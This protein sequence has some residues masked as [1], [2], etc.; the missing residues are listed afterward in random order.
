MTEGRVAKN[1]QVA[2]VVTPQIQPS[3]DS[4]SKKAEVGV[5]LFRHFGLDFDVDKNTMEQLKDIS[6]WAFKDVDT[7]G[8][9]LL[10]IR[11]LEVTLGVPSGNETRTDKIHRWITLQKHIEDLRNRQEAIRNVR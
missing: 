8:D 7:V 2:I 9:G 4:I 5:D 1:E 6:S 10:K 11:N 3:T